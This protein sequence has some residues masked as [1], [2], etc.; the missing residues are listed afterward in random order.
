MQRAGDTILRI[1][2]SRRTQRLS[3]F[4]SFLKMAGLPEFR[5]NLLVAYHGSWNRSVPTGYKIVRYRLDGSGNFL[6]V[7]DF[8]TGWLTKDG[9]ALG[10]PVDIMVRPGGTI[11]VSDDKAGVIYRITRNNTQAAPAES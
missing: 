1:S 5:N 10:R 11:F 2:T 9:T 7:D 8:L 3:V 4:R 6:R